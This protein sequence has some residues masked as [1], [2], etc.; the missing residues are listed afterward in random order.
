MSKYFFTSESVTEGHPDK[1]CD[2]ISD[3]IL[4]AYLESDPNARVAME[5]FAAKNEITIA[6][7]VTSSAKIGLGEIENIVRAAIKE[8]GYNNSEIDI[9]YATCKVNTN[10]TEQSAD[11]ALGV[12]IGGAGDQ[13]IMFG[14]ATDETSNY[15][16]YPIAVAHKLAKKLTDVRKNGV[17]PYLRPDGK[18]QVTVEYEND[19]PKRVETVLI[20]TQHT[21]DVDLDTIK[22]D[23]KKYVINDVIPQNMMDDNTKIY[24]NPTGRFII[25]GPLGDTGLT[26]RKIIVD[27][28][29]GMARHGGGAFS[30]KDPSKVDRSGA[31]MLRHIA[32]NVVANNLAKKCEIQISYAIGMKEPLSIWI[33]TYGTNTVPESDI[34]RIIKE[35]FDLT[36]DGIIKYLDLRK[37]I[38]RETTNYGHFGKDY[39][40]WE[41]IVNFKNLTN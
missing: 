24:I 16:P 33:N 23:V 21:A 27:T 10:I 41:K 30:G 22:Q 3:S 12:D 31:Y 38:Y 8:I 20:S 2:Y 28:Y 19:I 32:K 26:G 14:Y 7:Q 37:P 4:D 9:D 39:L 17:I 35:N 34:I 13:G 29:G 40:P 5:T 6:G 36:L 25:G 11:I 18:T 15:M 1:L